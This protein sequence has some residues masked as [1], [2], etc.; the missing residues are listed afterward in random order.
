MCDSVSA[1][2]EQSVCIRHTLPREG[3]HGGY[4]NPLRMQEALG[5]NVPWLVSGHSDLGLGCLNS[6]RYSY[7]DK[8]AER[9]RKRPLLPH[10][11]DA[12]MVEAQRISETNL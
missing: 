8:G 2:T 4:R 9:E 6:V 3:G 1:G 12:L 10:H 11:Q 5:R 7:A